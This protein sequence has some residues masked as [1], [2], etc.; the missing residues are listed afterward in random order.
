[1]THYDYLIVGGG[2]AADAAAR[3]IR[4]LDEEG[5]LGILSAD[6]DPPYARPALS[7]NLWTDRHFPW[8]RA[9]LRTRES[10]DADLHL[11]T[12]V[13]RI[14]PK[15]QQVVTDRGETFGYQHLLLATGLTP[16]TLPDT[17]PGSVIY[18]RSAEDYR[19]L[20]SLSLSRDSF[21]V[22]GGGYIGAELAAAL[23]GHGRRVTLVLPGQVLGDTMFPLDA[24]RE[25]HQRFVDSGV[26]LICGHRVRRVGRRGPGGNGR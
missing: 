6:T 26:H 2:M 22:I 25:Y 16:R 3:G 7:K 17:E 12:R 15:D 14:L 11:A 23:V 18:Y 9:L 19:Q 20:M 1:M 13:A 24:A 21:L 10:T 5:T 4:E 8:H